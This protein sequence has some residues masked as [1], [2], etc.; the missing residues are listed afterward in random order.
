MTIPEVATLQDNI[1]TTGDVDKFTSHAYWL[2]GT[3]TKIGALEQ[4]NLLR[5]GYGRIFILQMPKYV[6]FLLK[7]E[8]KKFKHMLEFG[9]VGI[10]GIQGYSVDFASVTGG[11]V[12]NTVE[13][14]TNA[15]DDTNSIT[16][17]VYETQGSLIRTYLDFWITGVIDP[18][19]GLS[20]YHG[21]REIAV[22]KNGK[23]AASIYEQSQANQIME[24]LYVATDPT[25]EQ[26]EY[27]CLL[28][29]MFPKSS[30]HSHFNYEPG[31]HDLVQLSID[32]TATKYMSSQINYIG[33]VA[34]AKFNI[35]KNYLNMY[36]GY[37]A[38]DV[39]EIVG[40]KNI[41]DWVDPNTKRD[42]TGTY[43]SRKDLVAN[44]TNI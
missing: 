19:T 44:Y 10:D 37:T 31:S 33:K 41:S 36:S 21:A 28:T 17:K 39:S 35:L 14:P 6:E 30:D 16:I 4:Y 25:G 9:N 42:L 1:R 24:A 32:F 18:Y 20:H 26:L 43:M 3:D 7:D 40:D 38:D 34:L 15:K 27:A 12:G 23:A 13:I 22:S 2:G 5:T 8:T 11:Y 29:N